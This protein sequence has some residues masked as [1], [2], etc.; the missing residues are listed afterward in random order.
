MHISTRLFSLNPSTELVN[1]NQLK[2][3]RTNCSGSTN[4]CSRSV[5]HSIS[6]IYIIKS[7]IQFAV[8]V[9]VTV[10]TAACYIS[11]YHIDTVYSCYIVGRVN[12]ANVDDIS[13]YRKY[14]PVKVLFIP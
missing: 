5:K 9:A 12:L 13:H 10:I 8:T 4:I 2:I 3:N 1:I 11:T 6:T 14:E 7:R